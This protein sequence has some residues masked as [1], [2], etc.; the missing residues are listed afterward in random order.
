METIWLVAQTCHEENGDGMMYPTDGDRHLSAFMHKEDAEA[1]AQEVDRQFIQGI[2]YTDWYWS[3]DWD[4]HHI[5]GEINKVLGGHGYAV[6]P[7]LYN[8][9]PDILTPEAA[10]EILKVTDTRTARVVELKLYE[11]FEE[12]AETIV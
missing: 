11:P 5:L 3:E 9:L 4:W 10:E 1:Y 2:Y 8:P 12:M 7:D 6:L